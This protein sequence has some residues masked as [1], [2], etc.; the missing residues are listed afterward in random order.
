MKTKEVVVSFM[1]DCS[2]RGLSQKTRE[3]YNRHCKRLTQLSPQF[4]PRPEI[5]QQFLADV[6]GIYNADSHYRTWHALDNYAHKRFKTSNFMKSVTRPRVPKQIMP[7]ISITELDLLSVY[8]ETASPRDR[9]ILALFVDTAVRKGEAV[10]LRREDI[11]ADRIIIHGKTGYRVAPISE[12]ARDLILSLPPHEDGYVFHG[13]RRYKD[14]RLGTTGFYKVIRKCLKKIGYSKKQP[15]PQV[16]RRSF[17][18][19]WLRHGG[20]IK[21]LSQ[22]LGHSDPATTL[23]YYTPYL[24]EDIIKLHSEH[25]P[26]RKFE[27]ISK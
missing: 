22:V 9:A 14:Y 27:D 23:R 16:L 17:G 20:D 21:S 11:L 15:S 25:T 2:L 1:G 19:F 13:T 18:L 6:N 10:N 12:V 3:D 4:P 8:L 7:T 26:G 24:T 5:I